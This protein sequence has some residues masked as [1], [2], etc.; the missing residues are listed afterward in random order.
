MVDESAIN[1]L[2]DEMKLNAE[3]AGYHFS[4]DTKF[5]KGLLESILLN[6]ERYGYDACPCRLAIGIKERDLDII[7]PCDYRDVDL[8][9][10]GAC[11]CALYVTNEVLS[12]DK[13]LT[14]IPDRRIKALQ[15]KK[16]SESDG[17]SLNYPV[18]R[19]QVCGYTTAHDMP[20]EICPLCRVDRDMFD[21]LEDP[22]SELSSPAWRCRVC[23]FVKEDEEPPEKCPV[24]LIEKERFDQ[25]L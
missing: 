17:P 23:G 18:W 25:V 7:C 12:G 14:S 5:V 10:F 24:C 3:N 4:E 8:N 2:Y 16:E 13:K 22:S 19:C 20:P 9:E 1:E 6:R 11:F 15:E 21:K